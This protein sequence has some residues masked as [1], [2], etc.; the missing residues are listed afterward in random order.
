MGIHE[1]GSEAYRREVLELRFNRIRLLEEENKRLR[2][3]IEIAKARIEYDQEPVT[4]S[5]MRQ[6]H[7][8]RFYEAL[9]NLF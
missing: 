5:Y 4:S 1:P 3:T 2:K 8:L 6:T 7:T 9:N